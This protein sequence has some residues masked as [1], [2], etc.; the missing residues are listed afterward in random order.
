MCSSKQRRILHQQLLSIPHLQKPR[1]L[2]SLECALTKNMGGGGPLEKKPRSSPVTVR[3][4]PIVRATPPGIS[5]QAGHLCPIRPHPIRS[6]PRR[7]SLRAKCYARAVAPL[8]S[9]SPQLPR[10]LSELPKRASQPR[11]FGL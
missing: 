11:P 5:L 1:A 4:S 10:L 9:A 2:S 7:F 3:T 8:P 6:P